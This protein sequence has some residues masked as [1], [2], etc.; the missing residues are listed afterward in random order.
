MSAIISPCGQYRYLLKRHAESMS[1]MKT[2]PLF[3]MLNPTTADPTLDDLTIRRCRGFAK[4][5]DGNGL[6]VA[7]LYAL[8]STAPAA[9]WSHPDPVGPDNDD[10][11]WNLASDCGDVVCAWG[12]NAKPEHAARVATIL[13]DA[14]A[15]LWCLSTTND[16]SPRH[17]LYVRYQPLIEWR[18]VAASAE[19]GD[20]A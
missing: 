14:G 7:N 12:S 2:T 17:P 15:R 1:P 4:L 9:L 16:G 10:Y 11:L 5:W 8:R 19:K 13:A 3:V 18:P 20:K 6:T